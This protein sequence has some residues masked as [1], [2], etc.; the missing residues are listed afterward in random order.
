[1]RTR[2]AAGLI[3]GLVL[4][5]ATACGGG[6]TGGNSSQAPGGATPPNLASLPVSGDAAADSCS[7]GDTGSEHVQF[8]GGRLTPESIT[9][10]VGTTVT[11]VNDQSIPHQIVFDASPECELTPPNSATSITFNTPG[12][13]T[14]HCRFHFMTEKGEVIVQ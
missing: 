11:W 7:S 1:V 10:P 4:L 3:A 13:F 12:T 6:D 2:S 5:A 9:V 8:G 14:Y